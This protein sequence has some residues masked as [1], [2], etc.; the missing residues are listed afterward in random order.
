MGTCNEPIVVPRGYLDHPLLASLFCFTESQPRA[1]CS[2]LVPESIPEVVITYDELAAKVGPSF[3]CDHYR[4]ISGQ[5]T[6]LLELLQITPEARSASSWEG[7]GEMWQRVVASQ[8]LILRR[9]SEA[10]GRKGYQLLFRPHNRDYFNAYLTTS[11]TRTPEFIGTFT[12]ND[13]GMLAL[14]DVLKTKIRGFPA[15]SIEREHY[16]ELR[17]RNP[18]VG[19]AATIGPISTSGTPSSG[20]IDTEHMRE[21]AVFDRDILGYDPADETLSLSSAYNTIR[22]YRGRFRVCYENI[23]K[24]YSRDYPTWE[25]AFRYRIDKEGKAA[26]LRVVQNNLGR[27]YH[28]DCMIDA[29]RDVVFP[30]PTKPSQQGPYETPFI[31]TPE[32]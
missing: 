28:L 18:G 4:E 8:K 14:L 9:A 12:R 31:F 21:R 19:E 6:G 2:Y 17:R 26:G 23:L 5:V 22:R 20:G 16:R 7:A 3:S 15:Q 30:K 29:M 1:I 27:G 32:G 11:R 10:A 13:A 24:K 25:V